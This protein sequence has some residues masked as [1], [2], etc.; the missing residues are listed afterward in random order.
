MTKRRKYSESFRKQVVKL[1]DS[2]DR[3]AAEGTSGSPL[4]VRCND[5]LCV[6]F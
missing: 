3:T 4:A 1:A 6:R 5:R 2:P